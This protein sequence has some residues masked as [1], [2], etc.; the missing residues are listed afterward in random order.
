MQQLCRDFAAVTSFLTLV[1]LLRMIILNVLC[2]AITKLQY[3]FP[4]S[5]QTLTSS[6]QISQLAIHS[7][8]LASFS[9]TTLPPSPRIILTSR[10]LELRLKP[11]TFLSLF[12]FFQFKLSALQLSPSLS[13]ISFVHSLC[14]LTFVPLLFSSQFRIIPNIQSKT[15]SCTICSS[16]C[17]LYAKS[18]LSSSFSHYFIKSHARI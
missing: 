3:D 9:L 15:L 6:G 11:S 10:S 7:H 16:V 17:K 13:P 8:H 4:T 12:F 5:A 14:P 18:Q 2:N 1:L